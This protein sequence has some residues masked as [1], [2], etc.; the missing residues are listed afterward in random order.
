[1]HLTVFF[2]NVLQH[3][4]WDHEVVKEAWRRID[5]RVGQIIEREDV[6]TVFVMSDHGANEIRHS[7]R[8]NAWLEQEGYLVRERGVSDVLHGLGL[9]KKRVRPL[10]AR[11]QIEWL[12]RRLVP[13]TVQQLLPDDD[14]SV[15]KSAKANVVDWDASTAVAS[16]Q[17][18]VY[19]LVENRTE[20]NRIAAELAS[21]LEGH[22]TPDGELLVLEVC[23]A[24]DLY[25]GPYVD[26]GPDLVLRQAP[27]V[28]I[29]GRIGTGSPYGRPGKWRGENKET[30][31]FM[32]TGESIDSDSQLDD[33]H[34]TDIA[35][36][37]LHLH[38]QPVPEVMDGRV[39]T[40]LYA[41]DTP[42]AE[43]SVTRREL[44]RSEDRT[45]KGEPGTAVSSRLE[46]LGYLE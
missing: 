32:A 30:G 43:T 15:D 45:G 1:L 5:G 27:G 18:P 9:T 34:I 46:D 7:F 41:P 35:P 3:F 23:R 37:I 16:G 42:A 36:T 20:R 17:G 2:L 4:Y 29:E 39:R 26:D 14:G 38:G 24:R 19:V 12:L 44:G 40:D 21:K 25:D 6:E 33:M 11:F 22:T 10:L 31:L 13:D 28:H 8:I